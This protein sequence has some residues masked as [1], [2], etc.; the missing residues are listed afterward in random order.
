MPE[1]RVESLEKVEVTDSEVRILANSGDLALVFP[2]AL[3]ESALTEVSSSS[4][5]TSRELEELMTLNRLLKEHAEENSFATVLEDVPCGGKNSGQQFDLVLRPAEIFAATTGYLFLPVVLPEQ[6]ALLRASLEEDVF[7]EQAYIVGALAE[8]Q[9]F[10]TGDE[11]LKA[12]SIRGRR[13]SSSRF[14]LA[15]ELWQVL[16]EKLGWRNVE[17]VALPMGEDRKEV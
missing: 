8:S 15:P 1:M 13:C 5:P 16:S 2:R 10:A 14:E 17:P 11:R 4:E 7:V 9:A 12:L 6:M 3:W